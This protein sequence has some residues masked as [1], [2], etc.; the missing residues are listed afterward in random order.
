[1][2]VLHI[3]DL[4]NG[5][6]QFMWQRENSLPM[7]YS[8]S[9]PVSNPL[10]SKDQEELRWYL[11]D[12]LTDPYGFEF[13]AKKVEEKMT[14]WG[15]SLFKMVFIKSDEG[16]DPLAMYQEAIRNGL[17]NCELCIN[18]EDSSFLN[19][20]WEL[21]HDP[22][23]KRYL[24]PLLG[25]LY[26]QRIGLKIDAPE[27][28]FHDGDLFRILLVIS[29]PQG[30]DDVPY[31]TV[32]RPL[33]EALRPLGSRIK[34]EVL[35][36]PTFEA[37]V[38]KLNEKPGYY[39]LVHFDG[40]GIFES[41][42]IENH[43]F[44]VFEK[45]D[46][47]HFVS[48]IDLGQELARAKVTLF[49]LNA[50]QSA[51]EGENAAFS[52]VASQLIA[53]GAKG[54]V[55]MGYSVYA[56]TAAHFIQKLYGSLIKHKSLSE[57][58][59]VGRRAL[60]ANNVRNTIVGELKFRDWMVPTVYQQ[61]QNYIPIPSSMFLNG[62]SL[63]L[64]SQELRQRVEDLSQWAEQSCPEGRFGFI[65]RDN[66]IL[67]I[68]RELRNSNRPW[69]LLS[70]MGGTGKT[71]LAYGFARW[72][73]ETGG[74]DGGVF[75]A[76]FKEKCDF[77]QIV[78]ST[79]GYATDFSKFPS[80]EQFKMLV[81][82]LKN[83][84]CLL[85]WDN[86]E[87]VS[88]NP[89]GTDPL[90]NDAE[91][92]ILSRFL[93]SLRGGKSRVII[94]TRKE[95]ENWLGISPG[96]V[97]ISGLNY[98]DRAELANTIL[99]TIGKKPEDFRQDPN[100]GELLK[101]LNGHPRSLEVVLPLLRKNYP[102]EII[103]AL[104][105][106]VN[107]L[108]KQIEDTSLSFAFS[109]LSTVSKKHLPFLCLFTS[110]VSP[111]ILESFVGI[112]GLGQAT[113]EKIVGE[114]LSFE[115]WKSIL[116][117]ATVNGLIESKDGGYYKL[118]PTLPPFFRKQFVADFDDNGLKLLNTKFIE[119]YS[120]FTF[121][122]YED[123]RNCEL[124]VNTTLIFEEPNLLRALRSAEINKDW[125]S[126]E[127]IS[128][129]ILQFYE[130]SSRIAESNAL[131]MHFLGH[132]GSKLTLK[133][134]IEK[135]TLWLYLL[136]SEAHYRI[137]INELN[138]AVTLCTQM[139]NYLTSLQAITS[140]E[141]P[142]L[143]NNIDNYI[144]VVYFYLGRVEQERNHFHKA[145]NWY[146]K[147]LDIFERLG[148]KRD[149][150]SDYHQ[151]G[152]IAQYSNHFDE[153]ENWFRKSIEIRERLGLERDAASDYLHLGIIASQ[154]SNQ[155]D[156]AENWF[157]KA[158][159]IYERLGVERDAAAVYQ[160]LGIIASQYTN[161]SDKVENWFKKALEIFE[162]LGLEREMAYAYHNLGVFKQEHKHFDEAENWYR[163]ALEIYEHLGLEQNTAAVYQNL[164]LISQ[165]RQQLD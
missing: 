53:V 135:A 64:Q 21:I 120:K 20:P 68:E 25:G 106:E 50:C 54:V 109:Q 72:Y 155:S 105:H 149:V 80:E 139:L 95:D 133:D 17:E 123:L 162:R 102:S 103:K 130:N 89:Q 126:V 45:D 33:I 69:V 128:K 4:R 164:R 112:E 29:R 34:L 48:S 90:A 35:R 76:S 78:G 62:H 125:R 22:T 51:V 37:L 117:E 13:R 44:L 11:E 1:L 97:H 136:E 104:Q 18:S 49:V 145:E 31:G 81:G 92:Q 137:S 83:N 101:L 73:A 158:L 118:H 131:R 23:T 60:Y 91:K 30:E 98:R 153:A 63:D 159:E 2:N 66:D 14:Q 108:G 151:L 96:F 142:E 47:C 55:A 75:K 160:N 82:Y 79:V 8:Y 144:A 28:A 36:P 150:A 3:K 147:A 32:S 57:S 154:Y 99:N 156:K 93:K 94:T 61:E 138:K 41:G 165:K 113:Y 9:I 26:R 74:C 86:F 100:Y 85:I 119:F 122:I 43:G 24:A 27:I 134:S 16:L 70:G 38:E 143:N 52:S 115:S 124:S 110:R 114:T 6:I 152:M 77:G 58:V 42:N 10:D 5:Q 140:V 87:S 84:P 67:R 40:H 129:V 12:Y 19:I 132:I 56:S 88:G 111:K 157:R 121:D 39:N 148:L 141:D 107:T 71:E 146:K 15:E 46:K 59:A 116:E 7:Q 161:Q 65:G 127:F 163:K